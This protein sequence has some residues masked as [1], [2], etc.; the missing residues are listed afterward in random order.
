MGTTRVA[1]RRLYLFFI[2]AVAV[3]LALSLGVN[4]FDASAAGLIY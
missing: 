4:V 2:I 3:A 1:S